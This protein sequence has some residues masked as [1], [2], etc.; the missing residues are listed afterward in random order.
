[1]LFKDTP[2]QSQ[3]YRQGLKHQ[4][5]A[6]QSGEAAGDKGSKGGGWKRGRRGSLTCT[7]P[8]SWPNPSRPPSSF[9]KMLAL[10]LAR[11]WR[12]E[13]ESRLSPSHSHQRTQRPPGS[14]SRALLKE[15]QEQQACAGLGSKIQGFLSA[16][17]PISSAPARARPNQTR[18]PPGVTLEPALCL[19]TQLQTN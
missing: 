6:V 2:G 3:G 18:R 14:P 4:P 15:E 7:D 8:A 11:R 1:M 5:Y 9:L 16:S 17:T 19:G 12:W 10:V 13:A